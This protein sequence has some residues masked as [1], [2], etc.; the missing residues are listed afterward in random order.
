MPT[1]T[2]TFPEARAHLGELLDRVVNDREVVVIKR[3]GCD[4][5]A[6]IPADELRTMMEEIY[7][8]SSPANARILLDGIEAAQRDEGNR[9]R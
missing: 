3:R 1:T 7:L 9:A 2:T 6:L 8:F 5:V 4:D